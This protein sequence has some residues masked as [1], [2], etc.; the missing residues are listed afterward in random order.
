MRLPFD[1][2]TGPG[3]TA[4]FGLIVLSTDETVED[5]LRPVFSGDGV[6]LLHT[7]I[8]SAPEVTYEKLMQMKARLTQSAGLLPGNGSMDVIGYACTSG[9]TVIGSDQVAAAVRE[10]HP[11]AAVTNPA[12]AV[13]AALRH[14]N[15]SR[16]GL[17]SPYVEEVSDALC[18]LLRTEGIT[19]VTVGSFGQAEETVVARIS[20]R[21]VEAAICEIGSDPAIEAVFASCTN[22]HALAVIEACEKRLGKP[23][24][25][26]NLALAWHMLTLAGCP[27]EGRGPGRLF[28]GT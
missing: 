16:I 17:V 18:G 19:P 8:E 28:N 26:S 23:V 12:M 5:E 15:V 22:L 1:C 3:S 10:A 27:T 11:K 7:R 20:L 14:L 25:S 4:A 9:S 21:S 24:I 2:D 6:S 13:V